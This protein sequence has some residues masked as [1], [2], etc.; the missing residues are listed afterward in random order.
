MNESHSSHLLFI[1]VHSDPQKDG[2]AWKGKAENSIWESF[3][4]ANSEI[5]DIVFYRLLVLGGFLS[6]ELSKK[7][8]KRGNSFPIIS[9]N[10][11]LLSSPETW[12]N[13]VWIKPYCCVISLQKKKEWLPCV[14]VFNKPR[15]NCRTFPGIWPLKTKQPTLEAQKDSQRVWGIWMRMY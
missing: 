11:H 9:I 12:W 1:G 14:H 13:T 10:P 5:R 6:K 15:Y 2:R 7:G 8:M 3:S 4:E